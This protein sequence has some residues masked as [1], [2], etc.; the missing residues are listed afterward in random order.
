MIPALSLPG[1]TYMQHDCIVHLPPVFML[2][3]HIHYLPKFPIP[4]QNLI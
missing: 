2:V 3:L 4:F 1:M